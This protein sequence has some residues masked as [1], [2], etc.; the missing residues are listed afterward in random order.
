MIRKKVLYVGILYVVTS[1]KIIKV[2]VQE[3]LVSCEL[4]DW[5]VLI[6]KKEKQRG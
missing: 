6:V 5:Q 1:L 4:R 2:R 3:F